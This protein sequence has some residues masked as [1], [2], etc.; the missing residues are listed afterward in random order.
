[1]TIVHIT[2]ENFEKEVLKSD[3]PVLIDFWAPWCGPCKMMGPVFE[4]LSSEMTDLKFVK[5]DTQDNQEL[6][7]QFQIQGIPTVSLVFGNK[8]VDRFSGFAPK[9]QLK[10]RIETMMKNL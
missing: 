3:K 2:K 8:E 6:A 4:E 9:E 10:Q 7:Q 1:M 5:I